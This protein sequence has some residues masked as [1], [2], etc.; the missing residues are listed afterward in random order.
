MRIGLI[1]TFEDDDL[2]AAW[3]EVRGFVTAARSVA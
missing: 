2:K 1:A 3:E